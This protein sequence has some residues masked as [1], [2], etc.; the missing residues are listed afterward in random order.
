MRKV[1][2]D[3]RL[4]LAFQMWGK[5]GQA[6]G[7]DALL[8][9]IEA[10]GGF[11]PVNDKSSPDRIADLLGMS[12][13][14]FKKAVGALLKRKRIVQTPDGIEAIDEGEGGAAPRR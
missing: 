2:A 4:D 11:L 10:S 6:N 12:K 13:A 8:A 9:R 7:A 5:Q 14:S 1:R 3:N